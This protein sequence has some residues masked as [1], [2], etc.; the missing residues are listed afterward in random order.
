MKYRKF[1]QTDIQLSAIGLGC[2]GM[3]FAYGTP[4]NQESLMT[5]QE[6]L[7]LGINFWDTADI[8]G[9]GANEVLLSQM[10]KQHRDKIFLATKIGFRPKVSNP[11]SPISTEMIVDGSKEYIKNAINASLKRL[12][13]DKIDLLYLHRVDP[14]VPIEES[15]LAMSEFVKAGKVSYLGLSECSTEDLLRANAVWPIAAVQSEYSILSR[16][17]EKGILP[18]T[19]EL[20]MAFI[21]F[22]PLS[23]GLLTNK[24]DVTHLDKTDFRS[25]LPRYNGEYYEN[26]EKIADE[27]AQLASQLKVTP[28]Q[29][30]IAW[31]LSRGENIIPIP[32][33]KKRQYL[34]ENC[35]AV[36]IIL[37]S[38]N[39]DSIE[40]IIKR[41]PNIGPRYSPRESNFIN[42][43]KTD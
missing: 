32:G 8:Y 39:I 42:K 1:G 43:I 31:V 41:H 38:E 35:G 30:A 4:D 5:L 29:L 11:G 24:L 19:K 16:D 36:D 9:Q 40:E 33:T 14:F 18:L 27:F 37:S 28:A 6:S 12:D 7:K 26:N 13:I 25:R 21:P 22:A 17:V 2:M 34:R 15:I 23:R 20:G 3:S 10:L